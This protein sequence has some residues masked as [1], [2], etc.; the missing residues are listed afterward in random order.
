MKI[1]EGDTVLVIAG[2]DRGKTG[3]VLRVLA[4]TDRVVVE[5]ANMRTKH[6]RRTPQQAGQKIRYEASL[7]ASNV[8]LIDPK[9]KKPTR[10]RHAVDPKT[11]KKQRIAT[12]SGEVITKAARVEKSEKKTTAKTE[13]AAATKKESK[14]VATK[15]AQD[16][17][18]AKPKKEAFW[19]R[20]TRK[21]DEGISP[22]AAGDEPRGDD[23]G[24]HPA[25][26]QP[27]R[28]RES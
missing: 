5:G 24:D 16:D 9:T 23:K 14:S 26:S 13:Q 18:A 10:I 19:K 2:K 8:M 6:I 20:M 4:T 15:T 11:G 25:R 7:H 21:N 28:A 12:V 1:R 22:D 27:R 17:T 3:S